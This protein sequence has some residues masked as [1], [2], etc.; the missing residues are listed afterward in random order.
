LDESIN[1]LFLLTGFLGGFYH[2]F[3]FCLRDLFSAGSISSRR[4][5]PTSYFS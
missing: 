3:C 1:R 2:V 5:W 4:L